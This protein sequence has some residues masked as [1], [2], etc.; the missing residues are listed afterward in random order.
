MIQWCNTLSDLRSKGSP[1]DHIIVL[2]HAGNEHFQYPNP[3]LQR[4]C[5]FLV[6]Q[7]ASAVICQHS[8]VAGTYE[9]YR[10]GV[11]VYGQ[12]NF[13]YGRDNECH[14]K[15]GFLTKLY[16]TRKSLRF[17][18]I[19]YVR[20][21][22]GLRRMGADEKTRFESEVDARSAIL[23]SPEELN[24]RWREFVE[25]RRENYFGGVAIRSRL[26]RGLMRRL[27]LLTWWA[28]KYRNLPLLNYVRCESHREALTALL[29]EEL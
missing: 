12:G 21:N 14:S 20:T 27:G 28:R 18:F 5:R 22:I 29:S 13:A 26:L 15:E 3:W 23:N 2:L 9:I 16:L 1:V 7:G 24:K 19:P 8:H 10:D 11:I 4:L 25:A 17:E 6:D